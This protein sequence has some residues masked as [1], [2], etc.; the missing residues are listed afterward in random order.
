MDGSEL[1]VV[2]VACRDR[3]GTPY[4]VTLDLER[5]G[6]PYGAVGERCGWFLA[7]VGHL[8]EEARADESSWPDPD[9]RF[10]CSRDGELFEFRYRERVDVPVAGEFRCHV[11]S[12]SAWEKATGW[13]LHRRAFVEAWGSTGTAVRAVLTSTE[14]AE[15]LAELVADAEQELGTSYGESVRLGQP[16]ISADGVPIRLGAG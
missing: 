9:D 10:P 15:F 12:D 5:D 4:E 11:R 3:E 14:L 2:P 16:P 6:T 8:L 13:R 1:R 7:R